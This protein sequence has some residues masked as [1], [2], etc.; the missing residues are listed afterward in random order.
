MAL[1]GEIPIYYRDQIQWQMFASDGEIDVV[2]YYSFPWSDRVEQKGILIKVFPDKTR[3]KYLFNLTED[4]R[5]IR[6]KNNTPPYSSDWEFEAKIW[7]E[8]YQEM[9]FAKKTM[10]SIE[11]KM[12]ASKEKLIK[13]LP[14]TK[15][16]EGAGVSINYL[17]GRKGT[18][19]MVSATAKF[20]AIL[21]EKGIDPAWAMNEFAAIQDKSRKPDGKPSYSIRPHGA[22]TGA[23]N[24]A[25][26]G[27]KPFTEIINKKFF[28]F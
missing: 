15:K 16:F 21:A 3:Q 18:V 2:D 10:D 7:C 25:S 1:K 23:S 17:A 5:N 12:E 22:V 28:S 19:D 11:A 14:E 8:A 4:F 26:S 27:I 13:L 24:T 9:E 6:L 20:I